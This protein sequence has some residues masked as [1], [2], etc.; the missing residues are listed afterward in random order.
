MKISCFT[1]TILDHLTKSNFKFE[2][3][4]YLNMMKIDGTRF[5]VMMILL[6]IKQFWTGTLKEMYALS[7]STLNPG[8]KRPPFKTF[9][10]LMAG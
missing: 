2:L 7:H 1:V 10:H 9:I 3:E 6:F 5:H 4:A 8:F